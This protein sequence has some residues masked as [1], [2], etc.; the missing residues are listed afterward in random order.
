MPSILTFIY[1][2]KLLETKDQF[3]VKNS[4]IVIVT[5]AVYCIPVVFTLGY[6]LSLVPSS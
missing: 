3:T 1:R 5:A 4:K 6:A 2:F